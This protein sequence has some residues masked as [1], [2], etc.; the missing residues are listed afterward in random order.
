MVRESWRHLEDQRFW[1]QTQNFEPKTRTTL[2]GDRLHA[3]TE[4]TSTKQNYY[5]VLAG[6]MIDLQIVRIGETVLGK[7]YAKTGRLSF[8]QKKNGFPT[9]TE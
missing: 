6:M 2:T 5:R 3:Y 4:N 1:G 9:G 8:H 7:E